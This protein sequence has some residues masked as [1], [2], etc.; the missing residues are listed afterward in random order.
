MK[1]FF[2]KTSIRLRKVLNKPL[3]AASG[4]LLVGGLLMTC[5]GLFAAGIPILA[6][7]ALGMVLTYGKVALD[8]HEMHQ[9]DKYYGD[10]DY[11]VEDYVET[12]TQQ[13]EMVVEQNQVSKEIKNDEMQR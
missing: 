2:N 5:C 10:E 13:K 9:M 12:K 6:G 3:G 4:T 1:D 11:S 7:G 8:D